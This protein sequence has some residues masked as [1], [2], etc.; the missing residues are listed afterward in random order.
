M[1]EEVGNNETVLETCNQEPYLLAFS[2]PSK[3]QSEP[4]TVF[5]LCHPLATQPAQCRVLENAASGSATES[6]TASRLGD[7]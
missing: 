7:R 5:A 2:T 6:E 3:Q 4:P 1:S